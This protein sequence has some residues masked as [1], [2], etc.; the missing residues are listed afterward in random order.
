MLTTF[1]STSN[2][3]CRIQR[4]LIEEWPMTYLCCTTEGTEEV[5]SKTFFVKVS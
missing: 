4:I 2:P 5:L 1:Q 3:E